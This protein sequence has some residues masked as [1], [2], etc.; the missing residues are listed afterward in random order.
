MTSW[1]NASSLRTSKED[2]TFYVWSLNVRASD[3]PST[4]AGK[5][6]KFPGSVVHLSL[7]LIN[8]LFVEFAQEQ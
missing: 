2:S 8:T 5:A 1:E 3:D 7:H 4:K 6:N